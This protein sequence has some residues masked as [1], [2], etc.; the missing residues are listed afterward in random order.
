MFVQSVTR[1]MKKILG[2]CL[3]KKFFKSYSWLEEFHHHE[4]TYIY[5]F[6]HFGPFSY[7]QMG[8]NAMP[9]VTL[10]SGTPF[11]PTPS[12]KSH[13]LDWLVLTFAF[14]FGWFGVSRSFS[15]IVNSTACRAF[16]ISH[17]RSSFSYWSNGCCVKICK[18][19]T[20][21]YLAIP[22]TSSVVWRLVL[23]ES[24]ILA[25]HM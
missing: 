7:T 8:N 13:L 14:A 4:D 12:S 21:S 6:S 18:A 24:G 5:I 10:R 3:K 9:E 20:Y 11:C 17:S 19:K 22:A 2:A 15:V 25:P 23:L 1:T 16:S